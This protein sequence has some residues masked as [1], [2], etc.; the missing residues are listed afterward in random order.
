MEKSPNPRSIS[1]E[2]QNL[3][4]T[5][6]ADR[7]VSREDWNNQELM[8]TMAD[9][10]TRRLQRAKEIYEQYN[11]GALSLTDVEKV[12]LAFL[13]QHS[14]DTDDYEKVVELGNA[15]GEEGKWIA[16]AGEDRWLISK[17]DKQK[18]GTQFTHDGNPMPMLSDEESGITDEMRRERDIPVRGEQ[19][20]VHRG[21]KV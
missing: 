5:D 16:A 3:Y 21:Q 14:L 13:F 10:D 19:L 7:P 1:S 12:Q 11:A 18:W 6:Q 4:D 17:G 2:L 8:Q 9:N 15:A 20:S